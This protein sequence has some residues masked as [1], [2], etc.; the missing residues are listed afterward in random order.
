MTPHLAKNMSS[1]DR[2]YDERAAAQYALHTLHT[3]Y[4]TTLCV[5]SAK[6]GCAQWEVGSGNVEN[7]QI[8]SNSPYKTQSDPEKQRRLL[9][10]GNVLRIISMKPHVPKQVYQEDCHASQHV[11]NASGA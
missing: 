3:T 2:E 6:L 7:Q 9:P 4:Q 5:S 1:P 10:S 11:T 8:T